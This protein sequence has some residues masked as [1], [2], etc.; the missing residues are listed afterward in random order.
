MMGD[1]VD[2]KLEY[3]T[4]GFGI[5]PTTNKD[6]QGIKGHFYIA[7]YQRGYRWTRDE[8]KKLLDDISKSID[9]RNT[10]YSLQPVVVKKIGEDQ[11]EL[12]DGQQRLTTLWLIFNYMHK[13]GYKSCGASYRLAYQTRPGSERYLESLDA[14]QALENIDY[15]HLHQAH[16]TI[17]EWFDV[18]A[19]NPQMKDRL[20]NRIYDYLCDS[21]RVIWYEAPSNALPIPLFT[22]LNRGRIPLTDAEL[23]KAVLLTQVQVAKSGRET[24]IAAQWDGI[25]RDLQ[26]EE[27]WAFVSGNNV[28]QYQQH[29]PRIGILLDTLAN[30]PA[31]GGHRYHTFD[32][33][34]AE[35]TKDSLALW[36]EV[37]ALHAQILGWFEAPNLYNKI[38]FLTACG[39]PIGDI[40]NWAKGKTKSTFDELLTVRI[41]STLGVQ[42]AELEDDSLS[43]QDAKRG[44][45][46]LQQLLLLFNV[47][48]CRER[49]P[50]EKHNGP[51][52]TLEHIHAQNAQSLNRADQWEAWLTEHRQA[53]D[54]IKTRDNNPEIEC[55]CKD[56]DI[57]LP[58]THST[59]FGERFAILA[60]R[61]QVALQPAGEVAG[62][63]HGISNLALLSH[64]ANSALS[65]AVFEVKRQ[66]VLAM[67]RAGEYV[68]VAT[69]NV[70]L[71][72]YTD[73][74]LL[75]PHFWGEADKAAYLSEIKKR[76]EPYLT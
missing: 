17:S 56:I 22:R 60:S 43:Y 67:D 48:I 21:V 45:L 61:V 14:A 49:F 27:I 34:Q 70:F 42:A 25:E 71:K 53:L 9:Q 31:K 76:L 18:K 54:I 20:V 50:F 13:E 15:F 37:V 38:G 59:G 8:V 39:T 12:I 4:I 72:Y 2:C 51:S 65:N 44:Y 74:G 1:M 19:S 36:D 29:G 10:H 11:W 69:R 26:R 46:K 57:A 64:S 16:A 40:Q 35:I 73:Q 7:A 62:A 3:K 24:E 33:L 55:L 23:V 30:K 28:S 47:Q 75:Q 58:H 52:W 63:D 5:D 32:V 41:K 66:K 6:T 68:P